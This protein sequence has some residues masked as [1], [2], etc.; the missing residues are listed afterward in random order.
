MFKHFTVDGKPFFSV[1]GQVHNASSDRLANLD[2]AF[3]A[4]KAIDGNTLSIP[5]YWYKI[6]P[7]EG[8]YDMTQVNEILERC[9]NEG[10]KLVFLWFGMSKNATMKY[11]PAWVK[12][13]PERFVR[14]EDQGH[15]RTVIMSPY[16][17]E[18]LKV[19]RACF[20]QVMKT[21]AASPYRDCLLAVQIE[22]E[23]GAGL[24]SAHDFSPEGMKAYAADV[25]QELLDFI[26]AR[27]EG[28]AYDAWQAAGAKRQGSWNEVFGRHGAEY[29]MA[30]GFGQYVDKLAVAG[31][32]EYDIMMYVNAAL[33]Y[34]K[35]NF[36]GLH[37]SSGGPVTNAIDVW[38]VA[39]PHIDLLAPDIY[40]PDTE[41]FEFF[42]K[43]YSRDDNPLFIPESGCESEA[44]ERLIFKGI[45]DYGCIG[46]HVFGV[47]RMVDK[48]GNLKP[49]VRG[50]AT[51]LRLIAHACPLINQYMETPEKMIAV[52]QQY[53]QSEKIMQLGDW[54]AW[55]TFGY[56]APGDAH[57]GM[58][59]LHL[60]VP[61]DHTW[62]KALI[63]QVSPN[64]FY[65]VGDAIRIFLRRPD[66][67]RDGILCATDKLSDQ[68]GRVM[69]YTIHEEG[70]FDAEGNYI[71][72]RDRNGDE[73]DFGVW[74]TEDIGV[75]HFKITD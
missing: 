7:Q 1:G 46:H 61:E 15:N 51:S 29:S 72:T 68:N 12:E 11:A 35:F 64:E 65:A 23:V 13:D 37:Y 21:I 30:W 54:Q 8:V 14:L 66:F 28:F 57:V 10:I 17:E 67:P 49:N 3:R 73:D 43:H 27:G 44:N 41:M 26:E 52:Y 18:T 60:D 62:G 38:K 24:M 40:R 22:N 31:K 48:E 74:L 42:M 50:M 34:N 32:A 69:N 56:Q 5:L 36:A 33:D 6:E 59:Y 4:V 9:H 47:E 45:A 20:V 75:V 2:W 25:P 16:C 39:A 71:V 53:G 63:F 70:Y 58:D 55:V 19:D